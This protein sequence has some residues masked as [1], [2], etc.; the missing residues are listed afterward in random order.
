VRHFI[1]TFLQVGPNHTLIN[2]TKLP[3]SRRRLDGG[4]A[5]ANPYVSVAGSAGYL[6]VTLA[7]AALAMVE[8]VLAS[9]GTTFD[10]FNVTQDAHGPFP[11]QQPRHARSGDHAL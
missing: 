9:D 10:A 1:S 6:R 11:S 3:A 4:N 5:T 7:T 2:H 8:Y